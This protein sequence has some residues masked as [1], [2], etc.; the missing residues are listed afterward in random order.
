MCSILHYTIVTI[1][2]AYYY[3]GQVIYKV[4]LRTILERTIIFSKVLPLMNREIN[5]F[6]M[7]QLRI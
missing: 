7:L 3:Y 5:M 4:T 1:A 6:N 2:I